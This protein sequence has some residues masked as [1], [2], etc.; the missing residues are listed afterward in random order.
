MA[1]TGISF[2]GHQSSSH[3][4]LSNI[5]APNLPNRPWPG[6]AKIL[7]RDMRHTIEY[8]F[9]AVEA[10]TACAVVSVVASFAM[11]GCLRLL[12]G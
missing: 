11:T 2:G 9:E 1:L 7:R 10:N 6:H 3:Q 8:L 12:L 5:C 4:P